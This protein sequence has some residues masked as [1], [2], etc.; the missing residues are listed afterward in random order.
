[1]FPK[2]LADADADADADNTN[3]FYGHSFCF[4]LIPT[5]IYYVLQYL[6][7]ILIFHF[8]GLHA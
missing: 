4:S 5:S 3:R 7:S 6:I 1:M 8:L 2:R